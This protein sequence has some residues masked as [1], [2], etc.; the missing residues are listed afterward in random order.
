VNT[1][2]YACST[3]Q[4]K[5][6]DFALG[7]AGIRIEPLPGLKQIV[8]PAEDGNTFEE[9]ARLK[10][11]YY[12]RFTDQFV[13]ADDS[14]IEVEALDGAPG[15]Y[16]ARYAGEGSTDTE[17]N[18]L[19]LQNLEPHANRA[20]RYVGVLALAQAGTILVTAQ[21]TVEGQIL[22]EPRGSG[23]FGYDPL[24]FYPPLHRCFAELTPEER[25]GVSHRGNALRKLAECFR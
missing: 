1:L 11:I 2:L 3:N 20:A 9:N 23:G 12:S 15:V 6:A 17:N 18:V 16:S 14:G 19:L 8:P 7:L 22:R 21:G 10:A 13:L 24:F 4:G 5:L 25:F